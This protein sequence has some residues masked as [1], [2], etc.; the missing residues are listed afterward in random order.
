[1][2]QYRETIIKQIIQ[3]SDKLSI[4]P[5][6]YNSLQK[7][8]E[9]GTHPFIIIRFIDRLKTSLSEIQQVEPSQK[10]RDNIAQAR[11]VLEDYVVK[12]LTE[13]KTQNK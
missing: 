10:E 11:N 12:N 4:E 13:T 9:N 7:L 8:V 5:L 1:M 2:E 6:I 3:S